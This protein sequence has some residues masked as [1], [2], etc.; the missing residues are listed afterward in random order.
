M[1]PRHRPGRPDSRKP[2]GNPRGDVLAY[3]SNRSGS[4]GQGAGKDG[5]EEKINGINQKPSEV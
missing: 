5:R 4:G 1:L 3:A 2:H